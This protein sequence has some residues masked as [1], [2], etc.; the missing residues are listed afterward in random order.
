MKKNH[1][2]KRALIGS[3]MSLVLCIAMLLGTTL[4]W[5]TDMAGTSVHKSE[6]G[7]LKV[8]LIDEEGNPLTEALTWVKASRHEE[9]EILW[10]PGADETGTKAVSAEV[11]LTDEN[12]NKVTAADNTFF[13]LTMQIEKNANVIGFYH[14]GVEVTK[15][16]S[17][18]AVAAANDLYYYDAAD[19]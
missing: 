6:S 5:F 9:E 15:A 18:E 4:A 3:M 19:R 2:T 11:R 8:A 7:T 14:N 13:V 10:E 16:E 1:S 12:G 17:A